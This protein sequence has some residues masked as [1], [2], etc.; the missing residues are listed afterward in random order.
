[1]V[2]YE[3]RKSASAYFV[4]NTWH[5][6]FHLYSIEIAGQTFTYHHLAEYFNCDTQQVISTLQLI[7][8]RY[9]KA[10]LPIS[11]DELDISNPS[12]AFFKQ[13][14][15]YYL[16]NKNINTIDQAFDLYWPKSQQLISIN[17]YIE[18]LRNNRSLD[19]TERLKIKTS[20]ND[21]YQWCKVIEKEPFLAEKIE[22]SKVQLV[23]DFNQCITQKDDLK[24]VF[25][26]I[27]C[28][29]WKKSLLYLEEP[30]EFSLYENLTKDQLSL[31]ALDESLE[32][33]FTINSDI[34]KNVGYFVVKPSL[35][36]HEIIES[37]ILE[38]KPI[39]L[40]SAYEHPS[41]K[42]GYLPY[43]SKNLNNNIH[44]LSTFCLFTNNP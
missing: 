26:K 3:K 19:I 7:E 18:T 13:A 32:H 8:N 10:S 37:L 17:D 6:C 23:F 31:I 35:L 36:K 2:R 43:L 12:M 28:A 5:S 41:L 22:Q 38:N 34:F 4:K 30:C 44:G 15:D 39:S 29:Y 20:L 1:M 11:N 25:E 14:I 16:V 40:S 21:F 27:N 42:L 9:E 24:K 33:C